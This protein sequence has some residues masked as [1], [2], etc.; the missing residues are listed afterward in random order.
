MSIFS[1]KFY[2]NFLVAC[3]HT[4]K[5]TL[6]QLSLSFYN[7]NGLVFHLQLNFIFFS[8]PKSISSYKTQVQEK[9]GILQSVGII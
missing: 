5:I 4:S 9:K 6:I 2:G 1:V 7:V 8:L 3:S